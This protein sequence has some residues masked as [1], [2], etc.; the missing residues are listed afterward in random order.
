MAGVEIGTLRLRG[1]PHLA[2]RAAFR[3]EDGLR[4][5]LADTR[6][7][8]LIRRMRPERRAVSGRPEERSGAI[9]LAYE[10]ATRDARHGRD[11]GD[12]AFL[13]CVWFES[14]AE[15]RRLLLAE[16]LAGRRP[17]GWFWRLAVP[18]W[19]GRDLED[20]LVEIVARALGGDGEPETL[21]LALLALERADIET[22][23]RAVRRAVGASPSPPSAEIRPVRREMASGEE[24]R[25]LSGTQSVAA[26]RESVA[27]LRERLPAP[28]CERIE[29]LVRRLGPA[30]PPVLRLL[31][32]LLL[33]ASPSLALAPDQLREL[34]RAW[35]E[36]IQDPATA[37]AAL[38]RTVAPPAAPASFDEAGARSPHRP[39]VAPETLRPEPSAGP[40]PRSAEPPTSAPESEPRVEVPLASVDELASD[41]AGLWLAIPS[42]I[43]LGF[44]EWLCERPGLLPD[45][46]GR[47]LLR[48][49][50]RHHRVPEDDPALAAFEALDPVGETPDWAG[51]W[52]SGLDGWL[53]RRARIPLHRLVW[54]R[55]EVTLADGALVV[56]FPLEAADIRL[57]RRALDVDPGWVDWLGLSVRYRYEGKGR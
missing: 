17:G 30:E 2:T 29:A 49:I 6:R 41:A 15:A 5:E 54:K 18:E 11:A 46:A 28:L 34:A 1:P 47:T 42:L 12:G 9:R 13:N 33:Q 32:R 3:I 38:E 26:L 7:L 39:A 57:R 19:R 48:T 10:S 31:E 45:D 50:A 24:A 25:P 44:R 55:G 22:V 37:P 21:A 40:M 16:L 51:C 43:R 52:R 27:E 4:T 36:L 35:S 56:R 20:W 23:V 14:P 53:R 8:I